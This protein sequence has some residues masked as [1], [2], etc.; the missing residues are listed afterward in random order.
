M[1]RFDGIF[2]IDMGIHFVIEV[3]EEVDGDFISI[4]TRPGVVT[5][6]NFEWTVTVE[7]T[8]I[9]T[10]DISPVVFFHDEALV[11]FTEIDHT[12]IVGVTIGE[13]FF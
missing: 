4:I 6:G 13:H 9:W 3:D 11:L 10:V 8:V 2:K 12:I 5:G 7:M 1:F